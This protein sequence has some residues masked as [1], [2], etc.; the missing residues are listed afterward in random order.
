MTLKLTPIVHGELCN[1]VRWEVEDIDLLA[2][3]VARVAMGQY[4]HVSKILEGLAGEPPRSSQQHANDAKLKLE[5][6]ADG[7]PWHRDGWIFQVL[8]WMAALQQQGKNTVS[9]AP[10][11]YKAHKG[12]DG[13]QLELA[14]DQ[15][16]VK[17]I[18]IFEDKA[19]DNPR[20]T[21]RDEVWP[22]I[23][24]LEQGKRVGEL[25]SEATTLLA[26]NQIRFPNMDVDQA[27]DTIIWQEMRRYRV[28]ITTS[29]THS[30]DK[31]R[32]R[33]FD[34]FDVKALGDRS[35]RTG[36]TMHFDDLRVWMAEFVDLVAKKIDE[37]ANV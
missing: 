3:S 34:G 14:D 22:D 2:E 5:L 28:S 12:F 15:K 27:I 30:S 20:D 13:I 25:T 29:A 11:I 26:L 6:A 4:R 16:T 8:S 37:V 24:D 23:V 1:G 21:I 36:E 9:Q 31:A 18:V 33:L 17:A 35:R 19:T 7:S 10:H 32:M